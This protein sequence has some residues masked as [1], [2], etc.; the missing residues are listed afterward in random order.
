M[1]KSRDMPS[2]NMINMPLQQAIAQV[3]ARQ[4][5]ETHKTYVPIVSGAR[6]DPVLQVPLK[7]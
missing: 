2:L 5:A 4:A 6:P 1:A 7:R 3:Q